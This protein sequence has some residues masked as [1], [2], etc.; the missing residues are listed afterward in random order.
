MIED[1]PQFP[2][3][4][5][6]TFLGLGKDMANHPYDAYRVGEEIHIVYENEYVAIE[7]TAKVRDNLDKYM[8]TP[9]AEYCFV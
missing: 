8:W 5:K 6:G 2:L 3:Y 9:F 4:E 1:K 7:N